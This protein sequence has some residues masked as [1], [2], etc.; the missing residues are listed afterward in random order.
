MSDHI[1]EWSPD[2]RDPQPEI[3][4]AVDAI[5]LRLPQL[6]DNPDRV[7]RASQIAPGTFEALVA[8]L[9]DDDRH[10]LIRRMQ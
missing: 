5:E 3:V 2:K 1:L 10:E 6:S 4:D 9:S 7:L 8:R